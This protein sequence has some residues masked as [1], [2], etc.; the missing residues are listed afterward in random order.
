[1]QGGRIVEQGDTAVTIRSPNHPYTRK[2]VASA[3]RLSD[4]GALLAN[5]RAHSPHSE[6]QERN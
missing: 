1:M 5:V 4:R 3:P 2:L 6:E